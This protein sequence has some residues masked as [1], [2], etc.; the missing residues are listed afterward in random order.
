[1]FY[2]FSGTVMQKKGF[3]MNEP[4]YV[5][6]KVIDYINTQVGAQILCV[7]IL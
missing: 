7:L 4:I 5:V 2:L 6:E 1:M 3:D